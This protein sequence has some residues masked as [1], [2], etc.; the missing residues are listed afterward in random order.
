MKILIVDDSL[1]MRRI[2]QR[3]L[4][5]AGFS[6][7]EILEAANGKLGLE[8]AQAQ[9]PD[10]ILSDWNMPEMNGFEFLQALRQGGS[11]I[12]FG[13]ITTEGTADMRHRAMEAGANFLLEKPFTPEQMEAT[14]NPYLG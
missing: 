9:A 2:I 13:F 10:V 4:R 8:A 6:G 7:H 5:Q 1:A 14:L 12:P 3:T 11:K